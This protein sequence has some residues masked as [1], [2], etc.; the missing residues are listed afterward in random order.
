MKTEISIDWF[1][2]MI[3]L[4]LIL[5][6]CISANSQTI[7]LKIGTSS[8]DITPSLPVALAGQ[9]HLRIAK[10][11]KTPLTANVVALESTEDNRSVDMA[12]MVACDISG[13]PDEL[14]KM[15]RDEVHKQIAELAVSKILLTATH[16]HT[17]PVLKN[18][19]AYYFRYQIPEKG[20]LQVNVYLD[21]FVQRVTGA[22]VKAWNSRQPGSVS[23][24]LGHAVVGYNRR[25]VYA[26][27]SA[28]MYGN[29]NTP[30]F[31]KM[32]A[33]E[34]HDINSLFFW[35]KSG[36][37][38]AT[39]VS[40][41][42]PAQQAENDYSVNAD[43]WH[44]VRKQ[45]KQ[46]FGRDLCVVGW[47]AAAGD[48]STRPMYRIAAEK[49]MVRLRHL[50]QLEEMGR[51]VALAVEE[52]YETVKN[53]R[54]SHVQLI[55]KVEN[56]SLPMRLVT[57]SEYVK[58][59]EIM[60]KAIA[61]IAADPKAADELLGNMTW[62]RGVVYRYE[63]QK[64]NPHPELDVE[65]HVLRLGDIAICTSEF[66]LFTDYS[67]QIQARSKALQTFVV[68]LAGGSKGYIPT[69]NATK[70]GG[71]SAVIQSVMVGPE[72][73]RILVERTLELVN[74]MF[75]VAK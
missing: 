14:I 21:F 33:I 44:F 40:V 59:K 68:Q 28:Q 46:R 51:R 72:G 32:E 18:D 54:Y 4:P 26:D 23:W 65:V 55:H 64:S 2:K 31:S 1:K 67:T 12:I 8:V 70:R 45:L 73:G 11:I 5:M 6:L 17:A 42:C 29:T 53:D 3:L 61:Q 66:E 25:T 27:G 37:L 15:V 34:D 24:G 41:S 56:L 48:M 7:V 22:I 69:E 49:R 47:I 39:S 10:E 20:V 62:H 74:E 60:D 75:K 9:M 13:L 57:E 30:S 36:K 19:S 71:Y 16:T 43:Y 58:C 38:I 35:D 63:N 50:S 52:T